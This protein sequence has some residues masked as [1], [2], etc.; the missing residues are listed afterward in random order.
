MEK[1][2][3]EKE[4]PCP[5]LSCPGSRVPDACRR[6]PHAAR[7]TPHAAATLTLSTRTQYTVLRAHPH[8]AARP[9]SR[10]APE[11]EKGSCEAPAISRGPTLARSPSPSRLQLAGTF[12]S[13][14]VPKNTGSGPDRL[15]NGTVRGGAVGQSGDVQLITRSAAEDAQMQMRKQMQMQIDAAGS[16]HKIAGL[17]RLE[18]TSEERAARQRRDVLDLNGRHRSSHASGFRRGSKTPE[19]LHAFEGFCR[20]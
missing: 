16:P 15:P 20:S 7:R 10:S 18:A 4:R 3:R 14:L 9:R 17:R 6:T 1:G 12:P 19:R 5:V 8:R 13:P 11:T 2:E